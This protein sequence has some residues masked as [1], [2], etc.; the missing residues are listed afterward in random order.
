MEVFDRIHLDVM[1][2]DV[3]GRGLGKVDGAVVFLDGGEIGDKV[4]V[5][6]LKKKK[7]FDICYNINEL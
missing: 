4:E 2:Y 3:K 5:E 1:D 7:N 6:I